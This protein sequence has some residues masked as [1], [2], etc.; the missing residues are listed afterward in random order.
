[1]TALVLVLALTALPPVAAAKAAAVEVHVPTPLDAV[2]AAVDDLAAMPD[3]VREFQRY[4]FVPSQDDV[5][6]AAVAFTLNAA[7]TRAAIPF[8][9]AIVGGKMLVRFDLRKFARNADDLVALLKI[10]HDLAIVDPYFHVSET[11]QVQVKPYKAADGNEYKFVNVSVVR[12][13]V[14]LGDP[15]EEFLKLTG[16][17]S[18]SAPGAIL[19]ADWFMVRALTATDGGIYYDLLGMER[20]PAKGTALDAYLGRFGLSLKIIDDLDSDARAAVFRSKV[21]GKPRRIDGFRGAKVKVTR[22]S[23][24][25]GYT[26]DIRDGDVRADQ[27]PL[28]NLLN[29]TAAAHELIAE[30]PNG[31]HEWTLWDA[32]G[33]LANSVPDDV[34]SDHLQPA[35]YTKRLQPAISCIRCHGA[36][37]GWQPVENDVRKMLRGQS[38]GLD[39]FDDLSNLQGGVDNTLLLLAGKYSGE[40]DTTKDRPNPGAP[41]Q[42]GRDTYAAAVFESTGG[43][44][45]PEVS[46]RVSEIY[47][48]YQLDAVTPTI[49]ARELGF[50]VDDEAATK[51][52]QRLLP[53]LPATADGIHPEDP[54]LGAL[55]AGLAVNRRQ[56]EPVFSDAMVRS[57]AVLAQEVQRDPQ[58]QAADS[59]DGAAA[60]AADK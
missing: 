38:G 23:G 36:F 5:D 12:P 11:Q 24:F 32:A 6:V 40:L 3:T 8:R 30:R 50:Q 9:P 57:Y 25:I 37:D 54:V 35:P 43:R 48:N 42:I 49:A 58:K 55:K 52:L 46:T 33:N 1:M 44:H 22:G 17:I 27:D 16:T 56:W 41:L 29:F 26:N 10:F 20:K 51:T 7:V 53:P 4:L 19:R 2:R 13:A 39:V 15:G 28:R 60:V 45:V 18:D 21:T 34:A 59:G 47:K 14:H 31:Y